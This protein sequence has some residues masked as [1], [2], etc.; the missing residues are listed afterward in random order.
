MLRGTLHLDFTCIRILSIESNLNCRLFKMDYLIDDGLRKCNVL[1]EGIPLPQNSVLNY[2]VKY[3][4]ILLIQDL[5]IY[6]GK[7]VAFELYL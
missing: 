7:S 2:N 3:A 1:L 6:L 4:L 5:W